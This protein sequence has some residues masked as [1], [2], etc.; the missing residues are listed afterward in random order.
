VSDISTRPYLIRAIY[1]WCV[2]SGLT[3]YL[4]V[5]VDA[6]TVVP[7]AHVKDGQIV[8]NLSSSAVRNLEITN[9]T[10]SCAGRFGGVSFDML[11]PVEAVLGIFAKENGQGLMFQGHEPPQPPPADNNGEAAKHSSRPHLKVVK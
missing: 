6:N 5:R 10:I 4:A 3:P 11:V 8:L 1:E 9:K 7:P 2:D